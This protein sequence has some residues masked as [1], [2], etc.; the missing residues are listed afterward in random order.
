MVQLLLGAVRLV[1]S[2]RYFPL[3]LRLV[4]S[5]N[6][7]AAATGVYVPVSGILLEM[8]RWSD[9]TKAPKG[10]PTGRAPST[11]LQLRVGKTTLRTP[12]FQEETILQARM[13]R[14]AS[15][16]CAPSTASECLTSRRV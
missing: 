10:G 16:D 5:L 4:R 11:N 7:L 15:Q 12:A 9:L 13:H 6:Q 3:R 14:S 2:P 1:P 8:L